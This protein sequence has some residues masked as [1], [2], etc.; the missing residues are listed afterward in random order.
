MLLGD[1]ALG[2]VT[3]GSTISTGIAPVNTFI[4]T[5]SQALIVLSTGA[6]VNNS[7][8]KYPV[9]VA[10]TGLVLRTRYNASGGIKET[11]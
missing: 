10:K 1:S 8:Q 5:V 4:E 11:L 7:C 2:N 6:L 3:L 9:V